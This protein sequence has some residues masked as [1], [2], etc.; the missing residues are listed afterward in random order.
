MGPKPLN[1]GLVRA[2]KITEM[3][4]RGP[5]TVSAEEMHMVFGISI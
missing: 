1:H 5:A 2:R 4:E 3:N